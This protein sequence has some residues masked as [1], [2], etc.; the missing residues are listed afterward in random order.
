M[1]RQRAFLD[2]NNPKPSK[3]KSLLAST[4][5]IAVPKPVPL[6]STQRLQVKRLI[7]ANE[8][9]KY[10]DTRYVATAID[11]T[12]TTQ[13]ILIP[14][15]GLTQIDRVGTRIKITRVVGKLYFAIADAT[16]KIR[17]LLWTQMGNTFSITPSSV[18]P[19]AFGSSNVNPEVDSN[20]NWDRKE[21]YRIHLDRQCVLDTDDPVK[22]MSFDFNPKTKTIVEFNGG[23]ATT[24]GNNK[25]CITCKSD[26]AAATHP[27]MTGC[28][29][30][31]YTDA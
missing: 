18:I 11:V 6:N 29:R 25:F 13:D 30:I 1:K 26:S 2:D 3:R 20:W 28:I 15:Q 17:L 16:N 8:E 10:W 22:F 19:L 12:G 21:E 27:T 5:I 7:K 4:A 24:T 31:Y 23:A 9:Q 14:V